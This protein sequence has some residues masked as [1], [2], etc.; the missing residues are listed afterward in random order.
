[1]QTA[2][3]VFSLLIPNLSLVSQ[4]IPPN[5]FV[6]QIMQD[7]VLILLKTLCRGYIQSSLIIPIFMTHMP[8][9]Y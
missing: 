4:S 8:V 2:D 1:M 6:N 9:V 7:F 3:I 5:I